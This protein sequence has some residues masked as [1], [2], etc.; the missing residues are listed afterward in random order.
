MAIDIES[1]GFFCGESLAARTEW[2]SFCEEPFGK[3]QDA[4]SKKAGTLQL[5]QDKL[6]AD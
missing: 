1:F 2:S 5:A 3:A 6:R 4:T